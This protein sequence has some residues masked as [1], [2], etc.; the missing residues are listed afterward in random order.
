MKDG[1][2]SGENVFGEVMNFVLN[3]EF[4][5]LKTCVQEELFWSDILLDLDIGGLV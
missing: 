4:E 3:I 2:H 1:T 5:V